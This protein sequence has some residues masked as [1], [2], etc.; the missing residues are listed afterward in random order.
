MVRVRARE[1]V[2]DIAA[3]VL[4]VGVLLDLFHVLLDLEVDI[5]Y[6]ILCYGSLISV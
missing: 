5:H 1:A 4:P 2:I 6:I 3:R